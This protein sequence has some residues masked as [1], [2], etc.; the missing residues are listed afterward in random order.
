MRAMTGKS[1]RRGIVLGAFSEKDVDPE[2][3][4]RYVGPAERDFTKG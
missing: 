3:M 1:A 2:L 4:Q